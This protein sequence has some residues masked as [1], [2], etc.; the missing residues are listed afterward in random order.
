MS[1][2]ANVLGSA[3]GIPEEDEAG[4]QLSKDT[5]YCVTLQKK[6]GML[7]LA[8]RA[9]DEKDGLIITGLVAGSAVQDWNESCDEEQ[10]I[11]VGDKI[12]AVNNEGEGKGMVTEMQNNSLLNMTIIKMGPRWHVSGVTAEC[13][14]K[15]KVAMDK[16]KKMVV[17]REE[18]MVE[19]DDE[20]Q[21][22][23]SVMQY[24][25]V[26]ASSALPNV[27]LLGLFSDIAF[28][29]QTYTSLAPARVGLMGQGIGFMSFMFAVG[30]LIVDWSRWKSKSQKH[31]T[32]G[33]CVYGFLAGGT[34]MARSY[35][36]LPLV[37][38]LLHIPVILGVLRATALKSVR[39]PSFYR[40]VAICLLIIAI[41]LLVMFL[42][43]VFVP[44]WAGSNVWNDETKADLIRRS[45]EM[46]SHYPITIVDE[47]TK[48]S[49]KLEMVSDWYCPEGADRQD[50]EYP[51][52]FEL[53]EDTQQLEPLI[54]DCGYDAASND[55]GPPTCKFTPKQ[56]GAIKKV[57]ASVKTTWLLIWMSPITALGTNFLYCLF[58]VIN[59]AWLRVT[60]L[61][62][63]EKALK[64]FL[65]LIAMSA[66]AGW[67][68]VSV[69]GASTR[70]T[71]ALL[72]FVAAGVVLLCIWVYLEIGERAITA[73][74]KNSKMMQKALGLA[75]SDW[76]RAVII[77]PVYPFVPA[78]LF[79]NFLNQRARRLRE[80]ETTEPTWF[81]AGA[82][83]I[84]KP[85]GEWKWVS[86]FT[87]CN[88]LAMVFWTLVSGAGKFAVVFLSWLNEELS[89]GFTFIESSAI[90]F[91]VGFMMFMLPFIPGIPVYWCAGIIIVAQAKENDSIGWTIGT[92]VA[93]LLSVVLKCV[94]ACGQYMIGYFLGWS[95]KVQQQVGV[96]KVLIKAIELIL[97]ERGLNLSKVAILI[98]GPDWP[99]S[100]LCGIL[101]INIPQMLIGT[102]PIV[103]LCAP[104]VLFGAFLVTPIKDEND[105]E[106]RA[107]W[108][109]LSNL[110]L[111]MS[112]LS[113]MTAVCLAL[114]FM[115]DKVFKFGEELSQPRP[116]H[117]KI[118]ELTESEAAWNECYD[119]ITSWRKLAWPLKIL[120]QFATFCM[121]VQGM[122]LSMVDSM[123][124]R[125]FQVYSRIGAPH[126]QGGLNN[127][128]GSFILPLG[129]AAMGL[130][131]F[132]CCAHAI[133]VSITSKMTTKAMAEGRGPAPKGPRVSF[134]S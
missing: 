111:G 86:I 66:A 115:Q 9:V 101:K 12:V 15:I 27:I 32:L 35:P 81:T 24:L 63:L 75:T 133:F 69:A 124:F 41:G 107:I 8:Y 121:I 37:I 19:E 3:L 64:N 76:A 108:N 95:V 38:V 79:V 114:Y 62:Q 82:I 112:A 120:I 48:K 94:A 97:Q 98:G 20:E 47:E 13:M 116:E 68:S 17:A 58:C 72:S 31:I 11:C 134:Q 55:G 29:V 7:G 130:F 51:V 28:G 126:D 71:G 52:N 77:V 105:V 131:L 119:D 89:E 113:Q 61:H 91:A 102:L 42:V 23:L 65:L 40:G 22:N 93:V 129:R 96:D 117:A 18:Q 59:G 88:L 54:T 123:C 44:S 109:T 56:F 70:L 2:I 49:V 118:I 78:L 1:V 25:L 45:Q 92:I 14:E 83:S 128:V 33:V 132:G 90:F 122:L 74:L 39:R 5:S 43:W 87:K 103:C 73:T 34:L 6:E 125:P 57:C 104:S 60:D 30:L 127:D 80:P 10:I 36:E 106:G 26:F 99:T 53:Y 4:L 50:P 100:V 110:M 84:F 85:L 16:G 67:V 46:Y 21:P